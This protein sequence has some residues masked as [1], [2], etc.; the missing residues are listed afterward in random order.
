MAIQIEV[1]GKGGHARTVG[2]VQVTRCPADLEVDSLSLG[3][4]NSDTGSE[5]VDAIWKFAFPHLFRA[6]EA[7][8]GSLTKKQTME[9]PP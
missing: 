7:S 2:D 9:A 5:M 3:A 8:E 6:F 4:A 1:T